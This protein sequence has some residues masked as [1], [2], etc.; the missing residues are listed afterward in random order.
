MSASSKEQKQ[1]AVSKAILEV[2]EK[3]GIA[4]LTHSKVARNA[5]VSRPWIYEYIGK[6]K[7][8]LAEYAAEILSEH[9]ARAKLA[10]KDLP[11]TKESLLERLKD[12]VE[13][14]L[15]EAEAN[16]T[17]VKLYYRYRGSPNTLGK[18]IDKHERLWSKT[19]AKLLEDI[20]GLSKERSLQ[21]VEFA[22]T[23]RMGYAHKVITSKNRKA[24]KVATLHTF[25]A[26]HNLLTQL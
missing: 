12:G 1:F 11:Q 19:A 17:V 15:Q 14:M 16:P 23:L 22:L 21:I 26:I 18:V 2:I 25:D 10:S 6:E 24:A 3:E 7:N 4:G 20:Y 8:S 9:F 13:F 5:K